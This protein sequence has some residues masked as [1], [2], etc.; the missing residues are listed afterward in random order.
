MAFCTKCG[1]QVPD[2]TAFCTTCGSP[3]AVAGAAPQQ[4]QQPQ[5]FQQPQQYQQPQQQYQQPQQ[6]YQQPQYQAVDSFDHT[7]EFTAKDISDNKVVA[8]LI[9]LSGIIGLFISF[10]CGSTNSP[11]A[12]FHA[13]QWLKI[14]VCQTLTVVIGLMLVWTII[15][16]IAAAIFSVILEVIQI[17]CFF[18]VCG[19]KAKEPAIVRGLKFLK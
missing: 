10:I 9:Y 5:Q 6:Q 1:A 11:Y 14:Y 17:I 12:S 16:P 8:M 2:G 13:R 4:P 3:M 18:Q 19:G 15:V 7:A